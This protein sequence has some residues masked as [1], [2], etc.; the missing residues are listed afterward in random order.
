MKY[1]HMTYLQLTSLGV[2]A[3][4]VRPY[5]EVEDKLIPQKACLK[6]F[7]VPVFERAYEDRKM[8][9]YTMITTD[10]VCVIF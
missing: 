5:T 9:C 2:P 10:C 1:I 4:V 3:V 8:L 6:L 7:L